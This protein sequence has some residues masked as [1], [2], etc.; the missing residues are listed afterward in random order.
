V[1]NYIYILRPLNLLIIALSQGLIYY[2]YVV[3]LFQEHGISRL[4]D[5][6]LIILFVS[7]TVL[8]AAGSYIINDIKDSSADQINKPEKCFVG[9]GKLGIRSTYTYYLAISISGALV[10]AY[11]AFSIEKPA[12][13]LIYP[14]AVFLLF[15]YS[16]SWKRRPLSGNIVVAT[17]CAFVPGI[18]W[19]AESEGMALLQIANPHIALIFAMYM[20]F[21]FLATLVREIIKDIEDIE[22]DKAVGYS[23]FPISAGTERAKMLA[24]FTTVMLTASY[25]LWILA[26][27]RLEARF[28]LGGL[29]VIVILPTLYILSKINKA[30]LKKDY[31]DISKYCKY[32]LLASLLIFIAIL[33]EI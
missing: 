1:S 17:F 24:I 32:L 27:V 4:L 18:I 10:A 26:L 29:A 7:V 2:L 20:L 28:S 8:I 15:M 6:P 33:L 22:G 9:D 12:L 21:G 25:G 16:H 30:T 5:G 11:I 23:T 19:Y 14:L 13:F 3:P 31:T